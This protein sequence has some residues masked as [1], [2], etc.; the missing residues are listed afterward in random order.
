MVID[1]H[2]HCFPDKIAGN[3]IR[4]LAGKVAH[5]GLKPRFDG[6]ADGLI[7][8][9]QKNGVDKSVVLCIA[10]NAK[11]TKNVN[12]FA[13]S[14]NN[15]EYLYAFGSVH[16]EFPDIYNEL[17]RLKDNGVRGIKLHPFYQ[18]FFIDGE[19]MHT[20]YGACA[21]LDLHILFHAGA[22]LGYSEDGRASPQRIRK[23]SEGYPDIKF[24]AAH[25]GGLYYNKEILKYLCGRKNIYL[26]TSFTREYC[27]EKIVKEIYENHDVNKILFG[28]DNPWGDSDKDIAWLKSFFGGE[29]FEKVMYKNALRFL[30]ER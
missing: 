9:M 8:N 19:E 23:I 17:K 20:I 25:S 12:D 28:S 5:T 21:E 16:P 6:T 1:F 26:D 7:F 2:T 4:E 22:D 30:G 24:I 27:D 18:D 29:D 15:T 11:Q 13:M 3:A 14:I 10:T